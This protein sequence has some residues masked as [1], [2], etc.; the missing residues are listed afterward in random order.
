MTLL[1]PNQLKSVQSVGKLGMITTVGI[2]PSIFDVGTT[3]GD[4]YGST[5]VYATTAATTV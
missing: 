5:L 4:A 3:D 2:Y 1:S